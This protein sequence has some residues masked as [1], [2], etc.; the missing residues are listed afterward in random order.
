MKF[1]LQ[2]FTFAILVTF[3]L[4][5][6]NNQSE[7]SDDASEKTE[8]LEPKT[9]EIQDKSDETVMQDGPVSETSLAPV[10][11]NPAEIKVGDI[12]LGHEVKSVNYQDEFV[13]EI[14]FIGEFCF[15]GHLSFGMSDDIEFTPNNATRDKAQIVI[16]DVQ[17][18]LYMWTT[19]TNI[20]TFHDGLG[21]ENVQKLNQGEMMELSICFKNYKV[22]AMEAEIKAEAEFVSYEL[23]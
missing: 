20:E 11:I 13:F 2:L 5:C 9:D 17:K 21:E 22:I 23:N 18:P 12:V 19:F 1:T 14:A 10:E 8:Q 15:D 7:T 4:S 3:V 6:Q 16:G